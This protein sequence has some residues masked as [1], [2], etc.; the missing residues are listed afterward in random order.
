MAGILSPSGSFLQRWVAALQTS[1]LQTSAASVGGNEEYVLLGHHLQDVVGNDIRMLDGI[2][3]GFGG[4]A[5]GFLSNGVCGDFDTS[6]VR[7]VDDG[8]HLVESYIRGRAVHDG[9]DAI[10]ALVEGL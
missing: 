7:F 9:L 10:G 2:R 5:R 6:G 8:F 1:C 4:D 3:A